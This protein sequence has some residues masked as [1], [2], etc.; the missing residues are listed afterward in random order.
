MNVEI[1]QRKRQK[2]LSKA[3]VFLL[4]TGSEINYVA[5]ASLNILGS[6]RKI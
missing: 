3:A 2:G 6:E 4:E 5:S 1:Q